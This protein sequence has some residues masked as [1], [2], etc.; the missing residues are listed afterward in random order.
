MPAARS[1]ADEAGA[2]C[3]SPCRCRADSAAPP[4]WTGSR[5]WLVLAN[6]AA[7]RHRRGRTV[8]GPDGAGAVV[9]E[10]ARSPTA[11]AY[12]PRSGWPGV[13]STPGSGCGDGPSRP[14]AR[15]PTRRS[16]RTRSALDPWTLEAKAVTVVAHAQ[17]G[18]GPT[19][20]EPSVAELPQRLIT[21]ARPPGAP[22]AAVPHGVPGLRGHPARPGRGG[23]ST[24]P[25]WT[26]GPLGCPADRA[27]RAVPFRPQLPADHVHRERARQTPSGRPVRRTTRRCRR[28]PT[29]VTDELRRP[30]SGAAGGLIRADRGSRLKSFFA[31]R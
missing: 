2:T 1:R 19:L 15:P 13:R 14:C 16:G 21:D 29:W 22:A 18:H 26:D 9:D 4:T 10:P 17:H 8:A 31:Q 5:W 3:W 24:V 30:P 25:R 12:G 7:R 6:L 23:P 27:G 11:S 28:T 20:V